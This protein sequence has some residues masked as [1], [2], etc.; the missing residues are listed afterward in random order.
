ML[1]SSNKKDE[2]NKKVKVKAVMMENKWNEA[3]KAG[4]NK[5]SVFRIVGLESELEAEKLRKMREQVEVLSLK[6]NFPTKNDVANIARLLIQIEEKIDRLEGQLQEET[7]PSGHNQ[8]KKLVKVILEDMV[9]RQAIVSSLLGY[10]E[11]IG[12]STVSDHDE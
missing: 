10:D 7:I 8:E 1:H 2:R 5:E 9:E 3:I 6:Y 11:K 12:R 4:L